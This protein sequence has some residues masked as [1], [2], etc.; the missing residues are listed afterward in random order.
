MSSSFAFVPRKV[1]KKVKAQSAPQSKAAHPVQA[2]NTNSH[3]DVPTIE[4]IPGPSSRVGL[5]EKGKG[6][7]KRKDNPSRTVLTDEDYAILISLA[8]SDHAIWSDPDLRRA[9]EQHPDK[10]KS[11]YV[12]FMINSHFTLIKSFLSVNYCDIRQ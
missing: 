12:F 3:Q 5:Q 2:V 1:A 11:P 9:I 6:K 10:C 7:H 4:N 8:L